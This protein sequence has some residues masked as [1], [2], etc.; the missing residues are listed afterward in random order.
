L[1][2]AVDRRTICP[3]KHS[4]EMNELAAI[5]AHVSQGKCIL[6]L[7]AGVHYPPGRGS[8]YSYPKKDRPPLGS[9]FSEHLASQSKFAGR[10]KNESVSNLQRVSQDYET[11]FQRSALAREIKQAVHA[12]K[13]PSPALCALARL[14]FPVVITTN[15]DQLFEQALHRAKKNPFISVYKKN[16][17]QDEMTDDYPHDEEPSRD[18]PFVFKIHG[19]IDKPDSIVITDE[20][21]IQFVLRMSD[22]QDYHPVP[23][24]VRYYLKKWPTLFIGYSLRD[25]NLRLLFKTL[26]WKLDKAMFPP[27]YSVDP[28]PDPLIFDVWYSQRRYVT[29]V[30]KDVWSFVPALYRA[31]MKEA[32]PR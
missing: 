13:R 1:L 24:T 26:R 7:G 31:V 12:G 5:A 18:R 16:E 19:D 27:A 6:F 10:F 25:Y 3:K 9:A 4:D 17:A 32:M 15:Y 23:E 30:A 8:P 22:K 21:Y 14:N 20:D 11:R 2:D 28:H 29:F